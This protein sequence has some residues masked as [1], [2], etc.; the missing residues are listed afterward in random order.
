MKPK[1]FTCKI[2]HLSSEY[3]LYRIGTYCPFLWGKKKT[4][5][6]WLK[7][8]EGKWAFIKCPLGARCYS[9]HLSRHLSFNLHSSP[10]RWGLLL[11]F[12]TLLYRGGRSYTEINAGFK[13]VPGSITRFPLGPVVCGACGRKAWIQCSAPATLG[14]SSGFGGWTHRT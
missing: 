4:W 5:G 11:F 2:L 8:G 9:K 6:F 3:R 7:E 13:F 12:E 1:K 10:A 14:A